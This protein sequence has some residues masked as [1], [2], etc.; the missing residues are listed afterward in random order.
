MSNPSITGFLFDDDNEAKMARHGISP[1]QV[2]QILDGEHVIVSNRGKRR[3]L[4]LFIG[5]DHGGACISVP[6]EPTHDRALWRP[7]TAWPSKKHERAR[8]GQR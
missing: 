1:R 6:V 7:I 2:S 5:Q 4:Y 3:G 8:L